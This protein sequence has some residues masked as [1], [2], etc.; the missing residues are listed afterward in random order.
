MG[1]SPWG[2][3]LNTA[4]VR[5]N[6]SQKPAGLRWR[7]NT[8][9]ILATVAIGLFTDLFLYSLVVPVIPFL[10]EDRI[11]VPSSEVQSYTSALLAVLAGSSFVFSPVAGILADRVSTRQA[12]F[13]LGIA[14]LIGSTILLFMGKSVAVLVVARVLQGVSAAV[15]WTVG[16]AMTIETV[17]PANLGKA[18]GT[19]FS[20]ITVGAL[21]APFLGGVLYDK[22]GVPG[23]LGIALAVLGIDFVMRVLV[24]EKKV[25][26]LYEDSE[27]ESQPNDDTNSNTETDNERTPTDEGEQQPLLGPKEEDLSSYILSPKQPALFRTIKILPCMSHPGLLTALLLALVQAIIFGSLDATVAIVSHELF[28]FSSLQAGLMFLPLGALDFRLRSHRWVGCR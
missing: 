26:K 16:L 9:F 3:F 19:M 10:L 7:S 17:G 4:Q 6:Y 15:V 21:W 11:G 5:N 20:F 25:A 24:I 27:R 18:I 8:I 13:L 2:K 22:T 12:P 23:V 1:L 28:G 14:A